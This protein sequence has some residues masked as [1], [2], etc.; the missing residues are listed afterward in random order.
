MKT[1][2]LL[3]V[4]ML[5]TCLSG[6]AIAQDCGLYS[7]SKG[8]V[9]GYQNTDGK[10]KITGTSR[11]T[12]L[13]VNKVGAAY[14]YKVRNEDFDAK[15][16]PQPAREYEMRCEGGKFYVNMQS[17]LDPKSMEGF[18]DMELKISGTDMMFPNKLTPGE[19]LPDANITIGAA[20]GG[21]TLMNMVVNIKNRK[22]VGLETV[23]VPAGTFECYKMT[24]DMETKMMF[25]INM[26]MVEYVNMGVGSVKTETYDK[27]GKLASS[28]IL[29]E[30]KK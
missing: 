29:T 4:T 11:T 14:V 18:K 16:K 15:N 7:L 30:I 26:S 21:M 22:V 6:V 24:S 3:F 13:D 12:C 27:K 1:N 23:T 25:T 2:K 5:A 8:M 28:H 17:F 20:S 10:G 19:S 9:M